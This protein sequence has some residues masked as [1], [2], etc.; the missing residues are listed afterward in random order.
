MNKKRKKIQEESL[1]SK[2][3]SWNIFLLLIF[4]KYNLD[5]FKLCYFLKMYSLNI[6]FGIIQ[7]VFIKDKFSNTLLRTLVLRLW[8]L[9]QKTW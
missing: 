6:F 3:V 1:L 2:S 8:S 9:T 4:I 7:N 5:L